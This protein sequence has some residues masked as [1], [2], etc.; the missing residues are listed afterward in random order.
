MKNITTISSKTSSYVF[1]NFPMTLSLTSEEPNNMLVSEWKMR[2]NNIKQIA[3]IDNNYDTLSHVCNELSASSI[4]K[5]GKSKHME[6]TVICKKNILHTTN[7]QKNVDMYVILNGSGTNY[8]SQFCKKHMPVI[9]STMLQHADFSNKT[10]IEKIVQEFFQKVDIELYDAG[11]TYFYGEGQNDNS[12][13]RPNSQNTPTDKI[14]GTTCA[15]LLLFP[16]FWLTAH[17]GNSRILLHNFKKSEYITTY[18]HTLHM[19]N[20][21]NRVK[22]S[23]FQITHVPNDILK[24]EGII[25][26]TRGF[27]YFHYKRHV[28]TDYSVPDHWYLF[29]H[30][31]KNSYTVIST[32][33]I[34]MQNY[35]ASDSYFCLASG[36][37]FERRTNNNLISMIN[38]YVMA[39]E[40][41]LSAICEKIADIYLSKYT[42]NNVSIIL[43]RRN[44]FD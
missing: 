32:P 44:W 36:S 30:G 33:E 2:I 37:L 38:E 17:I 43:V 26:I 39:G 21:Y 34:C 20:E 5:Q 3:N 42:N 18:D 35:S 25:P 28:A 24:F 27:G 13:C 41:D 14:G 31:N 22:K 15:M 19:T 40:F 8:A 7:L 11:M 23:G 1:E 4:S 29:P 6:D 12:F 10:E 9:L 16:T